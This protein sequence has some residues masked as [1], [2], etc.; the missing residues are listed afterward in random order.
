VLLK[1]SNLYYSKY[2][3]RVSNNA[4]QMTLSAGIFKQKGFPRHARA[5]LTIACLKFRLATEKKHPHANCERWSCPT[6][7]F[8]RRRNP[9]FAAGPNAETSNEGAGEAKS[10]VAISMSKGTK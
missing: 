5:D 9:T 1:A 4:A 6:H 2:R 7:P 8:G 10:R 3:V